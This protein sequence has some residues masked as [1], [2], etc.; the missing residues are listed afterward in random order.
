MYKSCKNSRVPS[1]LEY[2]HLTKPQYSD[3]NQKINIATTQ[4]AN[5]Q[6]LFKFQQLNVLFLD[7]EPIFSSHVFLVSFH[8]GQFLSLFGFHD[9][10][11]F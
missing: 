8:L 4:L 9:L 1:F 3:Q 5:L 6:V 10:D 2:Q 7:P 11:T